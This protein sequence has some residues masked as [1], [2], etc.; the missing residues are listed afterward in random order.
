M[1][2][3]GRRLFAARRASSGRLNIEKEDGISRLHMN[4]LL[5]SEDLPSLSPSGMTIL[6]VDDEPIILDLVSHA[7][8]RSGFDVR[9][10]GSGEQAVQLYERHR[11]IIDV[12]LIDVQMPGLDGPTTLG[13]IQKLNPRVRSCFMS[14]DMGKY[15][16]A[17]LLAMGAVH[18][19]AKP[20]GSLE[21]LARTLWQ[22][23]KDRAEKVH[24]AVG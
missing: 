20:F 21:E 19:L 6:V 13:A 3:S 4:R 15:A 8:F 9:Q 11:D 7:L 12:V 16:E 1:A 10:A 18:V 2:A 5:P 24:H 22:V 17:D 14:G 23:A